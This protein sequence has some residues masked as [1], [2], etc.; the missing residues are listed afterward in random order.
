MNNVRDVDTREMAEA[1]I[2][3]IK[4][5]DKSGMIPMIQDNSSRSACYCAFDKIK[6]IT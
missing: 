2:K 6:F 1:I 3:I 4:M 5:G